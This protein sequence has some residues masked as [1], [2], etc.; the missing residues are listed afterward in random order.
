[1]DWEGAT[2]GP[3]G[4]AVCS[5][6]AA[7]ALVYCA[8]AKR[9]CITAWRAS[10][11]GQCLW[12]CYCLAPVDYPATANMHRA[13]AEMPC[14]CVRVC[15]CVCWMGGHDNPLLPLL[16]F[17]PPDLLPSPSPPPAPLTAT[18]WPPW[19]AKC[20][21]WAAGLPPTRTWP[22]WRC[23]TRS[24]THGRRACRCRTRAT[25]PRARCCCTDLLQPAQQGGA[26]PGVGSVCGKGATAA[27]PRLCRG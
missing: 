8:T 17:L 13:T 14:W 10:Y 3:P 9:M 12:C 25:T 27:L 6:A 24:S 22:R 26:G 20:G 5:A 2:A 16:L 4:C 15:V 19:L 7:T 1:M 11:C 18:V 21:R 23:T